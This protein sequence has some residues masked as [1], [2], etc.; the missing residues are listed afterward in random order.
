MDL[1]TLAQL[2]EFIGGVGVVLSLIYLGVQVRGNTKS[3]QADITAR[4]VDPLRLPIPTANAATALSNRVMAVLAG[5]WSRSHVA[6]ALPKHFLEQS[7]S[8]R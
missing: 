8:R 6:A 7:L 4:V 2:G 5:F 1:A 3:Q